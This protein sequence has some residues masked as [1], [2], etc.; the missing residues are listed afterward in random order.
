[1]SKLR[2]IS[3]EELKKNN[4]VNTKNVWLAIKELVFDVSSSG[5]YGNLYQFYI[6]A[7]APDGS[8]GVFAGQ[9]CSVAFAKMDMSG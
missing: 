6:E 4:G 1:M 3:M 8:Y 7:Y 5:L 9:E 2:S